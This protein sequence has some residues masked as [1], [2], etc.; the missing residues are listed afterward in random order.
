MFRLGDFQNSQT[1]PNLTIT[2]GAT[3]STMIKW[4]RAASD[5]HYHGQTQIYTVGRNGVKSHQLTSK[6]NMLEILSPVRATTGRLVHGIGIRSKW[7]PHMLDLLSE[8]IFSLN[9]RDWIFFFWVASW[10]LIEDSSIF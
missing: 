6:S 1:L 2:P 5:P 10:V 4:K 8:N 3:F 9:L 7:S